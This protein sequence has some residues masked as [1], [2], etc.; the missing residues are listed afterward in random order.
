MS[1]IDEVAQILRISLDGVQVAMQITGAFWRNGKDFLKVLWNVLHREKMQ[2]KTSM[3]DLLVRGGDLQ[4][5]QFPEMYSKQIQ[6]ALKGYGILFSELPD[7]NRKDGMVEVVFHSEAVPRVNNLIQKLNAGRFIDMEQYLGN[8]E[9]K[10]MQNEEEY[11]ADHF[12]EDAKNLTEQEREEITRRM[13]VLDAKDSPTSENITIAKKLIVKEEKETYLTRIPYESNKFFKISKEDALWINEGKTM[14]AV[15]D[16]G[17]DYAVYD[18]NGKEQERV[19]G[20][21]LYQKH[22]EEVS[23]STKRRALEEENRIRKAEA[24]K[25]QRKRKKT[26]KGRSV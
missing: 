21:E 5:F 3:R 22:Y 14:L 23:L 4:I 1:E 10:S 17:K 2:G 24:R 9:G 19:N 18:R 25:R 13:K 11:F 20:A 7:L 8:A 15:I 12:Q 26:K 16:K 6:K